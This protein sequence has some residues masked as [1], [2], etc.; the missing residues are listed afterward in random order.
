M[1][2]TYDEFGQGEPQCCTQTCCHSP[3]EPAIHP[4][5]LLALSS[6]AV[7]IELIPGACVKYAYFI[8]S[9]NRKLSWLSYRPPPFTALTLVNPANP[10]SVRQYLLI[11][12]KAFHTQSRY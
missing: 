7:G 11:F 1:Y 5:L 12:S 6:A 10:D 9:A 4:L 8:T 3:V 2:I